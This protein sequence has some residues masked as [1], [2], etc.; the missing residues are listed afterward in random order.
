MT[1][2]TTLTRAEQFAAQWETMFSDVKNFVAAHGRFPKKVEGERKLALWVITQRR[3]AG[4]DRVARLNDGLPGW[5]VQVR[6]A[7]W[8]DNLSALTRYVTATGNFPTQLDQDR[9]VSRLAFWLREQRMGASGERSS[10]LDAA[11]PGWRGNHPG[12][13]SWESSLDELA[14]F[15]ALTGRRPILSVD[16][17][18]NEIRLRRWMVDQRRRATADQR[19][20]L[21]AR[22]PGWDST[23]A[24]DWED[25]L[26]KTK[27][28]HATHGRLPRTVD[29]GDAGL[30]GN[31]LSKQR[32]HATSDSRKRLN[33]EFPDWH[34]TLAE[35]WDRN[36]SALSAFVQANGRLP[37]SRCADA[38]ETP[39]AR[40]LQKQRA[41]TTTER[42]AKLDE[43]VPNWRGT[44]RK[45]PA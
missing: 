34:I 18:A 29:P 23:R 14:A 43:A 24:D 15:V 12:H 36:L 20:S 13:R 22:V 45:V 10:R 4:A 3:D 39:V 31:W 33:D 40:W 37:K 35:Q 27:A 11:V 32:I 21:N 5:N 26:A 28:F 38:G 17:S 7:A 16:A 9:S 44:P 2:D 6:I 19:A 30:L 42:A 8:E 1:S 25:R 41:N